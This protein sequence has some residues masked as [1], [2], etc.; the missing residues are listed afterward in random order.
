MEVVVDGSPRACLTKAFD[1]LK[2]DWAVG[3]NLRTSLLEP[4]CGERT[5]IEQRR[6]EHA[7]R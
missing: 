7:C 6:R 3:W 2:H 4:R 5:M 1:H